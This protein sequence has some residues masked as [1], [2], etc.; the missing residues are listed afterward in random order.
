[1]YYFSAL[2]G[3]R[4]NYDLNFR[5][6]S[7]K[8]ENKIYATSLFVACGLILLPSELLWIVI[9]YKIVN[10]SMKF[11]FIHEISVI[12]EKFL[13]LLICCMRGPDKTRPGADPARE[14]RVVHPCHNVKKY[15]MTTLSKIGA[16]SDTDRY[17][18]NFF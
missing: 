11:K 10:S 2:E 12:Q 13:V 15:E 16:F 1:V 4:Q 9:N 5:K 8:T 17:K 3:R 18:Y 6:S 14:P 7:I